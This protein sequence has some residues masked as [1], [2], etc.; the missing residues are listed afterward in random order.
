M[1]NRIVICGRLVRDVESRTTQN[2]QAVA[3]F[4]LAVDRAFKNASGEKETDFINVVTWKKLA[5]N[6]AAYLSKGKLAAIDGRLQIRSYETK[7]GQKRTV[8]EVVAEDVK[9]L[10]PR[11]G[12]TQAREAIVSDDEG[13]EIDP[14]SLPF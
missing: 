5:E 11:D 12:V 1:I 6:C 7:D 9:F 13:E 10:S 4:T 14:D 8:A 2:G 3:N